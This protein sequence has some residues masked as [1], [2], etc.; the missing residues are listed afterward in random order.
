MEEEIRGMDREQE[1]TVTA[2]NAGV[3]EAAPE[4]TSDLSGASSMEEESTGGNRRLSRLLQI[5]VGA[6]LLYTSWS[7]KDAVSE[8]QGKERVLIIVAIVF[9]TVSGII[10]LIRN[11]RSKGEMK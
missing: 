11:L 3:S 2:E 5:L 4:E 10:L 8:T 6:Y 1:E 7:L 9:F